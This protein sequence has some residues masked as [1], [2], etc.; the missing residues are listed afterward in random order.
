MDPD[1]IHRLMDMLDKEPDLRVEDAAAR[2][3][4]EVRRNEEVIRR[5]QARSTKIARPREEARWREKVRPREE[6]RPRAT[7]KEE[8]RLLKIETEICRLSF[9]AHWMEEVEGT[10]EARLGEGAGL[11]EEARKMGEVGLKGPARPNQQEAKRMYEVGRK[12]DSRLRDGIT[13]V[14]EIRHMWEVRLYWEVKLSE[15][16]RREETAR[17]KQETR[18]NQPSRLYEEAK[19]RSAASQESQASQPADINHPTTPG[20]SAHKRQM[21]EPSQTPLVLGRPRVQVSP[22]N[23]PEPPPAT[24]AKSTTVGSERRVSRDTKR[25]PAEDRLRAETTQDTLLRSRSQTPG[26]SRPVES[27]RRVSPNPKMEKTVVRSRAEATSE[28]AGKQFTAETGRGVSPNPNS[29]TETMSG[30]PSWECGR[31]VIPRSTSNSPPQARK[32]DSSQRS[33]RSPLR[34]LRAKE[35]RSGETVADSSEMDE[36]QKAG[37]GVNRAA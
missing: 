15:I 24:T 2:L 7:L 27:E 28:S 33:G 34:D 18:R 3:I 9:E 10:L 35:K 13:L 20:W 31:G 26:K 25:G 22:A 36:I 19:Q 8:A 4:D 1:N 37:R 32:T 23:F 6:A 30:R 5:V 17:E 12:W 16:A 14:R 21:E 11:I 29:G